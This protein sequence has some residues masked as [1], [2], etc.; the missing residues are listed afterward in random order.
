MLSHNRRPLFL[1]ALLL[2]VPLLTGADGAGCGT[3]Q[4]IVPTGGSG[5]ASSGT[6]SSGTTSS[7]SGGASCSDGM[8]VLATSTAQIQQIA[9]SGANLYWLD[10]AGNVMTVPA[11]SSQ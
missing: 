1:A 6:T 2:A 4:I 7:S 11:K 5:G 8:A 3:G 9:V 10:F